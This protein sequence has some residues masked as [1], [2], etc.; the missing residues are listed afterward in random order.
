[1][2]GSIA[3]PNRP[4]SVRK[5]KMEAERKRVIRDWNNS[6]RKVNDGQ[7]VRKAA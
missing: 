5:A 4:M 1:M 6:L 3:R 2:I 7:A